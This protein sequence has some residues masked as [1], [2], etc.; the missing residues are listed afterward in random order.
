[1][2][3]IKSLL[4]NSDENNT[5]TLKDNLEKSAKSLQQLEKN[6]SSKKEHLEFY[7]ESQQVPY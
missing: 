6:D 5:S 3:L 7:E 4:N 2:L 1:M